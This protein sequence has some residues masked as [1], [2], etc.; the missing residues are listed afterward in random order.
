MG[1]WTY[2]SFPL[3]AGS[4]G[5]S[6]DAKVMPP[7][8]AARVI[9]G[10]Y[11]KRG[12]VAKRP[13]F[14]VLPPQ[15]PS[16]AEFGGTLA[17]AARV[18]GRGDDGVGLV[19]NDDEPVLYVRDDDLDAWAPRARYASLGVTAH[20]VYA[21]SDVTQAV[22]SAVN[23]L[24][25]LGVLF[26][27]TAHGWSFIVRDLATGETISSPQDM[28]VP[29]IASA[30]C[31]D[32]RVVACGAKFVLLFNDNVAQEIHAVWYD[33]TITAGA[34]GGWSPTFWIVTAQV[35]G[36]FDAVGYTSTQFLLAN[37]QTVAG[38]PTG[39]L[40]VVT[41]A[42]LMPITASA[43]LGRVDTALGINVTAN[44]WALAVWSETAGP[45]TTSRSYGLPGLTA[46]VSQVIAAAT[47]YQSASIA[48]TTGTNAVVVLDDATVTAYL[49][50]T[51]VRVK[52]VFDF[53]AAAAPGNARPITNAHTF[54]DVFVRDG[55]PFVPVQVGP[56]T[57]ATLRSFYVVRVGDSSVT[58]DVK[59]Y[60]VAAFAVHDAQSEWLSRVPHPPNT[61][62]ARGDSTL[63]VARTVVNA[64]S[65]PVVAYELAPRATWNYLSAKLASGAVVLSGGVPAMFDGVNVKELGFIGEP[66][67]V[68][69]RSAAGAPGLTGTYSWVVC[70]TWVDR[71]GQVHRSAP[72]VPVTLAGLVN[73]D[74]DLLIALPPLSLVNDTESFS[75]EVYR[76]AS[77]GTVYYLLD[78]EAYTYTPGIQ[79]AFFTYTDTTTATPTT[80]RT[81]YTSGVPGDVLENFNGPGC[82]TV[83]TWR[84][85][86]VTAG[87]DDTGLIMFSKEMVPGE[88]PS[89]N[90]AVIARCDEAGEILGLETLDER[91]LVFGT[92]GVFEVSGTP[93]NDLGNGDLV[94]QKVS[95]ETGCVDGRSV[96]RTPVGVMFQSPRG[97]VNIDRGGAIVEIGW[98]VA[99]RLAAYPSVTSAVALDNSARVAFTIA[100]GDTGEVL[101]YDYKVGAWVEWLPLNGLNGFVSGA[102]WSG[103]Y[104]GV[105]T[106][107]YTFVLG[108]TSG[109][110]GGVTA[111]NLAVET[112]W[113]GLLGLEGFWRCRRVGVT[114]E[115]LGAHKLRMTVDYGYSTSLYPTT[116]RTFDSADLAANAEKVQIRV[117][118]QKVDSVRLRVEEL[119]H[120]TPTDGPTLTLTGF[121]VEWMSRRGMLR[122][123]NTA[124]K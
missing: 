12:A 90:D 103:Q 5:G 89:L 61:G 102:V 122:Q 84:N 50:C 93:Y 14:D 15:V 31:S 41:A 51:T 19:S 63:I 11:D 77:A 45:S 107:G 40:S 67:I 49:N 4:K 53:R 68:D 13:K 115:W 9:N 113:L 114:G 8:S 25:H 85:R 27:S 38:V 30:D 91:L 28:A 78:D 75:V 97:I 1:E 33:E 72:S 58:P 119:A 111:Y 112:G 42:A 37:V 64:S 44:G 62:A 23:S 80:A 7:G 120:T 18:F 26:Y 76:T 118:P 99:D 87:H 88:A 65:A 57:D 2:S 71:L 35:N 83:T 110:D 6:V 116:T 79:S 29:W 123:P 66:A 108:T 121:G 46:P 95:V 36:S 54:G 109:L 98:D 3:S 56:L 47:S 43:T 81:V 21:G 106:D 20:P 52:D 48:G 73:K 86:V 100:T 69:T 60:P 34:Y 22:R 10:V 74:V 39:M 124:K 32:A 24:G 101:V 96:V 17:S 16:T 92:R 55:V 59:S 105:D 117:N 94:T 104:V 70:V 82:K